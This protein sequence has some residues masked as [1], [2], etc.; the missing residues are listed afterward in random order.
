MLTQIKPGSFN[1]SGGVGGDVRMV[2]VFGEDMPSETSV[3]HHEIDNTSTGTL[4]GLR[5]PYDLPLTP[6]AE[7]DMPWSPQGAYDVP[8]SLGRR[9][10][11]DFF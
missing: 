1:G 8:D 2:P 9:W 7:N 10:P 4:V 3:A 6:Y 5:L 11:R